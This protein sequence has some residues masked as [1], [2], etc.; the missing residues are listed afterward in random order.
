MW[1]LIEPTGSCTLV[2]PFAELANSVVH[3][4]PTEIAKR[5]CIGGIKSKSE[6][7]RQEINEPRNRL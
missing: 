2:V 6:S 3:A 7:R 5:N 1:R 4:S